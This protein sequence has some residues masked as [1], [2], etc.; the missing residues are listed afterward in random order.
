MLQ[1]SFSERE[2]RGSDFSGF[3]S[4]GGRLSLIAREAL[5]IDCDFLL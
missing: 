1:L 3:F 2:R 5:V 4:E